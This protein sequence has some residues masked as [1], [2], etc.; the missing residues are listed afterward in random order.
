MTIYVI[1][2]LAIFTSF[3]AIKSSY[4]V[5]KFL[6][7]AF[8]VGVATFWKMYLPATITA[9]N[10][11]DKIIL[12][13][14]VGMAVAFFVMPF[15]Y[16]ESKNGNEVA[17]GFKMTLSR[18]SGNDEEEVPEEDWRDRAIAH[19]RRVKAALAGRIERRRR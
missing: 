18:L 6:A 1:A 19:E 2:G 11:L 17:R 4:W 13:I 7:G 12:I 10:A 14:L 5:L 16:T 9:G 3:M 15:W 8:W